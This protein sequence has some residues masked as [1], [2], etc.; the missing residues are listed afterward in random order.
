MQAGSLSGGVVLE[1]LVCV[2]AEPG[3]RLRLHQLSLRRKRDV[4]QH[5][6]LHQ[7]CDRLFDTTSVIAVGVRAGGK[8][9]EW[10]TAAVLLRSAD[11]RVPG[12]QC[13]RKLHMQSSGR[14]K[15]RF[16]ADN[17]HDRRRLLDGELCAD[18]SVARMSDASEGGFAL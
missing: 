9:N 14:R 12:E 13:L 15:L 11:E 6:P 7:Q 17:M 1:Q 16:F 5:A 4:L 8:R 10:R 18:G 2:G 3:G